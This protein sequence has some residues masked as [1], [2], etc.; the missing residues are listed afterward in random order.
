MF[1]H[2]HVHSEYSLLDGSI[3]IKD[4]PKKVKELGMDSLALTDHGNMFGII[5]FYKECLKENV[6]P[7][8]GCEVYVAEKGLSDKTR[9]NKRFHLILLAENDEGYANL[10]KI[11]SIGWV[12]GFYYKPRIDYEV[13]KKY[14]KGLI[15]LSACLAGEV[16]RNILNRDF[17]GAIE[18]AEKY[19]DIFG[20]GSFFLELQN[21]GI[22]EQLEVNKIYIT[23]LK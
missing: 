22:K 21:H 5:Q 10:M 1:T 6:K 3:R 2:L 15:A 7:I 9:D 4:L 11:V 8:L 23:G 14:S 13:L 20:E 18:A 16:Q 12:D 19:R 17:E